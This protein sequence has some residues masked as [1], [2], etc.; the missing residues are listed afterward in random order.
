MK[1][2]VHPDPIIRSKV[3]SLSPMIYCFCFEE[4]VTLGTQFNITF[5]FRLLEATVV[6]PSKADTA[7]LWA[8]CPPLMAFPLSQPPQPI[9]FTIDIEQC[10]GSVFGKKPDE[11]SVFVKLWW[12]GGGSFPEVLTPENPWNSQKLGCKPPGVLLTDS[13]PPHPTLC[14]APFLEPFFLLCPRGNSSIQTLDDLLT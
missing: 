2:K 7:L 5:F 1:I 8:E 11:V 9:I 12:G 4:S 3:L 14:E 6:L 10:I 13:L